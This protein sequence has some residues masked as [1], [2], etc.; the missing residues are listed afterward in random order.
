MTKPLVSRWLPAILLVAV[1]ALPARAAERA[2]PAPEPQA[3]LDALS[4]G[5]AFVE[6][7][8]QWA[9]EVRFRADLGGATLWITG[10]AL[11][12]D[13]YTVER[14]EDPQTRAHLAERD[15][16]DAAVRR[17][18]V[19]AMRFEEAQASRVL[20]LA[21]QAGYHNYFLGADPARWASRV[22]LY[23]EVVLENLYSGVDL[24]LYDD[25]GLL[26]YDLVLAPGADL[27]Q[28]RLN[29][30]GP[31]GLA[32]SEE[33]ALRMETSLGPVEQRGL[34]AYQEGP[35]GRRDEVE[36]AFLVGSDGT[37]TFETEGADPERALVVD[38]LIWSTYLGGGS[39]DWM[40]DLVQTDDG[41]PT[42]AGYTLSTDFPTST[43]AYDTSANGDY[44][45]F[46][47]QLSADGSALVWSTFFGGAGFDRTEAVALGPGGDVTVTGFTRSA[48]FSTTPGAY[49]T[50]ANGDHDGFVTRLSADG[51]ALVWSTLLGGTTAD[52]S[53]A[54]A[55]GPDGAATVVGSTSGS[56]FPT[57]PGAYD[58]SANGDYDGFV[59]R[60]S[61]DGSALVWS[62]FLGGTGGDQAQGLVLGTGGSVV[63]TG[64]TRSPDFP[65]TAGAYDTS[66]NGSGDGFVAQ[67]TADGSA[68]VWSTFLG[69]PGEDYP[70]AAAITP[71]GGVVVA[72]G[73][74]RGDGFPTTPGAFD[75][76]TDGVTDTFVTKLLSDGSALVWSTFLGGARADNLGDLAVGADGSVTVTGDTDSPGFPTT[77]DAFDRTCGTD[78]YGCNR[79][80]SRPD[81][82]VSRLAA[83]G[84]RLL[85]STFLGGRQSDYG[86]GLALGADGTATVS[87]HNFEGFFPVTPGAYNTTNGGG[88][89][90]V[91]RLDVRGTP[92]LA[93][94]ARALAPLSVPPGGAVPFEFTVTNTTSASVSGDLFFVARR[95]ANAVAS[96]VITAGTVSAGGSV[97]GTF[98]QQVPGNVP[99][100]VYTY[101]L[102]I[103][104]FPGLA[105]DT[106]TFSVSVTSAAR[107]GGAPDAWAVRDVSPWVS[108]VAAPEAA[109]EAGVPDAVVLAGVYPNPFSGSA[110]VRFD[111]PS[112]GRVR[113][114]VYDVLGREVAVL[115]DGDV[116]AGRHEA[117]L[118]GHG[119]PS[120]V[121]LVRLDAGGTAQTQRITLVR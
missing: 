45:G 108:G 87:G 91:T 6:N 15:R 67:L 23:D 75:T 34:L 64:D 37:V 61:A 58:T 7:R 102:S 24:R 17:G 113:L 26:R 69:G 74:F 121:Y 85:Y 92:P 114:V 54:V 27:G 53:F 73:V 116:K 86:Y 16:L 49:D 43:G 28:V 46:A 82:F 63:V 35:G 104:R 70:S 88:G 96:G 29:L 8:G 40:R 112:L 89:G 41:R 48:D 79:S 84:S 99:A 52:R 4:D 21:R 120:G 9:S 76:V 94:T 55:V 111:L 47:T 101:E 56:S 13:F 32:L 10:D 57:T 36:S 109:S 66:A 44:D 19:V 95:G 72:G 81:A 71:D 30:D 97:M 50:S 65:T 14:E 107:E 51:S 20:G 68:L 62:T 80:P 33:G 18:H 60:L 118:E 3:A 59:S 100:G 12:F 5:L 78:A 115:V 2:H 31:D 106:E 38:P 42:I 90:F 105:V 117:V 11:V 25:G 77:P 1:A 39:V 110:T 93:L 98:T 103:G 119:L 83:D 22:P